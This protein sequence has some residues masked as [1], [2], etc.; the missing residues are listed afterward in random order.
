MLDNFKVKNYHS[1]SDCL[2]NAPSIEIIHFDESNRQ[3]KK[4]VY[5]VSRF[6]DNECHNLKKIGNLN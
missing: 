6:L 3:S 1:G 4:E 2:V 5:P